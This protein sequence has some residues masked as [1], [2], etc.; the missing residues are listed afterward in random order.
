MRTLLLAIIA[1]TGL[2]IAGHAALFIF[3]AATSHSGGGNLT[4]ALPTGDFYHFMSASGS[5]SANGLAPT[6]STARTISATGST[7]TSGTGAVSLALSGNPGLSVG[8]QFAISGLTGTGGYSSL[9]GTWV[10]TAGTTGS[11]LNF[12]GPSS[13]GTT[14]ITGGSLASSAPWATPNHALNCGDVIIAS[15]GA[16]STGQF[17]RNWGAVSNCPSTTG[18]IDGTGGVYF[19]VALCGGSDLASCTISG[20]G[21]GNPT[22]LVE[23]YGGQSNWA[24]EGF[25][26]NSG[27]NTRGF[28]IRTINDACATGYISHHIAS[29]NNIVYNSSQAFGFNDCGKFAGTTTTNFA[30]YT[31][32][33]GMVAQNANQDGICLGAIDFVGLGNY[34]TNAGT[35]AYMY[36]NF[37]LNNQTVSGCVSLYDGEAFYVDLPDSH[38][39]TQQMVFSNNIGVMSSRACITVT[40]NAATVDAATFLIYN[41]TCYD[42]DVGTGSDND[43]EQINLNNS[44]N[45]A[46]FI[47]SV[48]D[49]ISLMPGATSSGGAKLYA[50]GS[51]SA[52]TSPSNV[53][54]G[55][56]SSNGKENIFKGQQ[57]VC[58]DGSS[59]TCDAGFNSMYWHFSAYPTGANTFI[60]PSFVNTADLLANHMGV[61]NCS[62]FE[63]ATQCMGWDSSTGTLTS[64]SVISDLVGTAIGSAPYYSSVSNKGYQLSSTTCGTSVADADYPS[65]LKGIVYLHWNGTS[66]TENAGLVTKPC[67]L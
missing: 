4:F 63:N 50:M 38:G 18:G 56:V 52:Y 55:A 59:I 15:A 57:T 21:S 65:W 37:A 62:G 12:T 10:A 6:A 32:V 34:D 39:F 28:G 46:P 17:G 13:L 54:V 16:Y 23:Y 35:H 58:S 3:A 40:Y 67:G 47:I 66:L 44:G 49:N 9:N 8:E 11:T 24:V 26:V 22:T 25:L 53:T 1:L 36:G 31:A 14:T 45:V 27:G 2:T 19:A 30:D 61:P 5:D 33:I 43:A 29:I 7:Y 41:N 42:N 48:T 64:L 20:T 60:D 51:W